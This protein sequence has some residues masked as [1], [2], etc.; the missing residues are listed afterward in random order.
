MPPPPPR[1]R[2]RRADDGIFLIPRNAPSV[3]PPPHATPA[4]QTP[5][6]IAKASAA[7]R[8]SPP[9]QPTK[10]AI[11]VKL[12]LDRMTLERLIAQSLRREGSLVGLIQEILE[13]A[14]KP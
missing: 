5:E 8:P 13:K 11:T 9:G 2:R 7:K 6:E 4:R 3:V 10:A 1:R 14:A 12:T